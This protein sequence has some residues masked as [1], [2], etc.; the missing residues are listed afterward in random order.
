MGH[1]AER[2]AQSAWGGEH[3]AEGREHSAESIGQI[4]ERKDG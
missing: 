4:A 3:S 2:I 1:S